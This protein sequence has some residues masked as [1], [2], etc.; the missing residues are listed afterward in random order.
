MAIAGA[1]ETL[2]RLNLPRVV[3]IAVACY[4]PTDTL[5]L[6]SCCPICLANLRRMAPMSPTT[7][8]NDP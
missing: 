5:P 8:R 4:H 1:T 2:A 7:A 6:C 3:A